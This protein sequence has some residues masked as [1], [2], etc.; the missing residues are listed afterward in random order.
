MTNN[1]QKG[2]LGLAAEYRERRTE[3]T[4]PRK[5]S[6]SKGFKP[7]SAG[8]PGAMSICFDY[9]EPIEMSMHNG[10]YV[11]TAGGRHASYAGSYSAHTATPVAE[12][13]ETGIPHRVESF[14]GTEPDATSAETIVTP[15]PPPP[16]PA[17]AGATSETE[18]G[19]EAVRPTDVTLESDQHTRALPAGS[20][21]GQ[22]AATPATNGHVA[23]P[24]AGEERTI[25]KSGQEAQPSYHEEEE[26]DDDFAQDLKD[27]L[28]GQKQYDPLQKKVVDPR[29]LKQSSPSQTSGQMGDKADGN[30]SGKS[31]AVFDDLRNRFASAKT[32]DLG[33]ISMEKRFRA[34]DADLDEEEQ[35]EADNGISDEDALADVNELVK[36]DGES[37]TLRPGGLGRM[38]TRNDL[39]NGDILLSVSDSS[40]MHANASVFTGGSSL[41]PLGD[42]MPSTLEELSTHAVA[43]VRHGDF[44]PATDLQ[45][46][47]AVT[48][49][50]E[51]AT[52]SIARVGI[53]VSVCNRLSRDQDACRV[54]RGPVDFA[55]DSPV[56]V[57]I[58]SQ[59]ILKTFES[60]NTPLGAQWPEQ[61]RYIGHLVYPGH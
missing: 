36:Q 60:I 54:Y 14:S 15:K 11:E 7:V 27:I 38:I 8:G 20:H 41:L 39:Q 61:L 17:E 48:S 23:T 2:I 53:H 31:H 32:I 49:G 6:R 57:A 18:P 34:F 10:I 51:P 40:A 24:N 13:M 26:D 58:F 28:S 55:T 3:D 56:S 4:R 47:V 46:A 35:Q 37:A 52:L 5:K 25:P 9:L 59:T 43:V 30:P 42:S 12:I 45:S 22:P 33:E 19:D 21:T 44:T 1:Y 29:E 50:G 16:P